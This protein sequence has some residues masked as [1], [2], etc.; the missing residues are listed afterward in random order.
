[1]RLKLPLCAVTILAPA[2]LL[3]GCGV[4][5]MSTV[6]ANVESPAIAGRT[7][8]GQQPVA[9]AT[10]SVVAMGTSGY[11]SSGTILASTTTQAD[12]SFSFAPGAYSCPQADT[13]V[14]VLGIGGDAGAG[15]NPSAVLAAGMGPCAVA[16]NGYL[17]LNEVTTTAVAFA[18]SH[19]FSTA[20]GGANAA[21]DWFGGPSTNSGGTIQYSK[22]L[23]A[24]NN[25]T[26][27]TLISN[28]I[29]APNQPN[30]VVTVEW[31]KIYTIANILGA[32]V[33]TNGPTSSTDTKSPCGKLFNYTKNSAGTRPTDTL[34]AAVQMALNPTTQVTNLYSLVPSTPAFTTYLTS[35]PNDWSIGVS[36]VSNSAGLAVNTGTLSTLDIDSAGRIWF[37]SNAS[38]QTGA[39][40]FDP[41]NNSFNGPYNTTGMTHP[42][43]VAI[44]ANGYAWYNDSAA[45]TVA[46]Y[47]VTGPA[48]TESV[49]LP[50]T[51][52]NSLTV[53]ADDRV[54][55]GITS[56]ATYEM[57]NIAADRS[58]YSLLSGV[59]F[60]YSV[61]SMAGD[62]QNG[63]AVG[64]TDPTTTTSR[65]YYVTTG[66]NASDVVNTNQE[67]GQVIYTGNDDISVRSYTGAGSGANDGLCIYSAAACYSF[68][69]GVHNGAQGI[70]IDGGKQLWVAESGNGGVLQ[71]TPSNSI[72]ALG[73]VYLNPSNNA[74]I[75]FDELVHDGSDGETATATKP[76]GI[77][78][79]ATGNLWLTNAGCNVTN[80]TPGTFTLTEIVG[81]AYP[82]IT[83]VSAQ[84][85][86]GNLVGTEPGVVPA[87]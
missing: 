10:I 36:Y 72:G 3:T 29:G 75:T 17:V 67:L 73:T 61:Q 80:C 81:A 62:T 50:A 85:T 5:Q 68:R 7:F 11:G 2:V 57:A 27:P 13:P 34:Q 63:D 18:L 6:T 33:N 30:G 65:N 25:Y 55:V 35:A 70:A 28:A 84:I 64:V 54:N 26:I 76:Y 71:V 8:G 86:S 69:G 48:V 12:G 52:S 46:G 74:N 78:V 42:Q 19:F 1:M 59:T 83:P 44:D 87:Q 56:G 82:T 51:I 4:N 66:G 32:C 37:P 79:D 77:G 49:S 43:Q 38:G 53:G 45:A 40:Y 15:N 22:G 41:S 60:P 21:N 31:Q 24:G 58:T 14:Y 39:V 20:L 16:K 23:V 9:G 47:L